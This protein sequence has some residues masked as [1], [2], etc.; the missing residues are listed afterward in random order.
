MKCNLCGFKNDNVAEVK[1]HYLDF[2][3]VDL[4]NRF[5]KKLFNDSQNNVLVLVNVCEM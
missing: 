2:H 1:K 3:K 4:N 5:F